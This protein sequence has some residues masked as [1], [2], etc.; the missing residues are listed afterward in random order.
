MI[1]FCLS[2]ASK[3]TTW[4]FFLVIFLLRIDPA[5]AQQ[6]GR[7]QPDAAPL[8]YSRSPEWF[9]GFYKPYVR[10]NVPGAKLGNTSRVTQMIQQGKIPLSLQQL[11][12]AVVENNLD[13]A[14][15]RYS[16]SV[17]ETDILRAKSGQAP[18]GI[19]GAPSP[20]GLFAGAIGAGVGG[21]GG[22]GAG[23]IGSGGGISGQARAVT[24]TPRGAFDP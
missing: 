10:R 19:E 14:A 2:R 21:A 9:P 3:K 18:R 24:I 16:N 6:S 12:S 11:L 22:G 23:G 4:A 5:M 15:A 20:S 13:I 8:D 17:A 1:R 7:K